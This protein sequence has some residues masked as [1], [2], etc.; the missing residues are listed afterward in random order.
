MN[1]AAG[2]PAVRPSMIGSPCLNC[3]DEVGQI[4][5][6][7]KE[8]DRSDGRQYFVTDTTGGTRWLLGES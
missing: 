6:L 4:P 5:S 1:G 8:L 3:K 7:K 2:G